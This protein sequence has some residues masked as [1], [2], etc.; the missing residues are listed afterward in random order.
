MAIYS[1]VE[2]DPTTVDPTTVTLAGATVALRGQ[3]NWLAH[4]EDVDGDGLLDL[5]CH[6][7]TKF[8]DE[9]LDAGEVCLT[10]ATFDGEQIQGCD[11]VILV[12]DHQ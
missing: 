7:E 11:L 9:D 1:S 8:L 10:G 12:P 6:V 4:E 5:V 3:A 2:F